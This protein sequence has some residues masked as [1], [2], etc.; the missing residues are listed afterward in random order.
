M[1]PPAFAGLVAAMILSTASVRAFGL[2]E[3]TGG[4]SAANASVL[5]TSETR[6]IRMNMV[7]FL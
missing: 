4:R 1:G 2:N 3:I 6:M 5:T 7:N